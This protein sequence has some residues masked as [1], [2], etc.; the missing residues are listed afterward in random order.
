MVFSILSLQCTVQELGIRT[1]DIQGCHFAKRT[2]CV[3]VRL[4]SGPTELV[5]GWGGSPVATPFA[6]SQGAFRRRLLSALAG[7]AVYR[8]CRVEEAAGNQGLR[9]HGMKTTSRNPL[10]NKKYNKTTPWRRATQVFSYRPYICLEK[11][12]PIR[13]GRRRKTTAV[14]QRCAKTSRA[15]ATNSSIFKVFFSFFFF[16]KLCTRVA[17]GVNTI[18]ASQQL[19]FTRGTVYSVANCATQV[20]QTSERR[21]GAK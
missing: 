9:W 2:V 13:R 19:Y 1:E 15:W 5:G 12:A 14:R 21:G 20:R 17:C 4:S 7:N 8:F 10:K 11:M 16:L 6:E 18:F 3:C